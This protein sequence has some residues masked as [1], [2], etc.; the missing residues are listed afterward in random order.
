[1]AAMRLA[2]RTTSQTL[3][4]SPPNYRT[5]RSQNEACTECCKTSDLPLERTSY[6]STAN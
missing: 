6:R 3:S 5:L 2:C 1:M 4:A